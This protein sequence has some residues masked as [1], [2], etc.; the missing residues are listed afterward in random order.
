M[1]GCQRIARGDDGR[2]VWS[3]VTDPKTGR[4]VF[5]QGLGNRRG[6]ESA[7]CAGSLA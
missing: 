5:L 7:N 2:L 1:L 3:Y 6:D 4:K